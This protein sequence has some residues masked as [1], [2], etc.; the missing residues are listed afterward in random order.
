MGYIPAIEKGGESKMNLS[1]EGSVGV[2]LLAVLVVEIVF[3]Y[4]AS[5]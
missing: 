2:L 3:F 1:L 5:K 4:L